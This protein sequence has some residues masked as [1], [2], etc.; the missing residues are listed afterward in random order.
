MGRVHGRLLD[1]CE[2]VNREKEGGSAE[3]I[4]NAGDDGLGLSGRVGKLL[5]GLGM[6]DCGGFGVM[7]RAEWG[8]R[9]SMEP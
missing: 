9:A 2:R 5:R 4:E 1:V 8:R 7:R 6:R 3:A